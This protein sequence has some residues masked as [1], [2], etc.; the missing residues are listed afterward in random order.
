MRAGLGLRAAY[1]P[2]PTAACRPHAPP[3]APCRGCKRAQITGFREMGFY[4]SAGRRDGKTALDL[5][6][7]ENTIASIQECIELLEACGA[8]GTAEPKGWLPMSQL[9]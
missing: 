9:A 4:S 3:N 8:P 7:E 1:A 6:K 5:A 2:C